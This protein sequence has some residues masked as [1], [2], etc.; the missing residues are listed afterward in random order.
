MEK[1]LELAPARGHLEETRLRIMSAARELFAE[2]GSRGTTTR[3]VAERAG[4]N[5]ATLFRHFGTKQQLLDAMREHYV[6]ATSMRPMFEALS[7]PLELQLRTI[8]INWL[9][10]IRQNQDLIRI[11][12]AEELNDPSGSSTTWRGPVENMR[13]LE[14]Y[15]GRHVADGRLRGD[16]GLLASAF[17]T[18][19]FGYVMGHS[20]LWKMRNI[21]DSAY[22]DIVIALF[23]RGALA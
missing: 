6:E 22:V 21:D 17:A 10:R 5:E 14:A 13:L 7:G 4:V 3:E 2:R 8:G 18:L 12:L 15:M 16:P 19:M 20:K 11:S 9:T 1:P 23:L